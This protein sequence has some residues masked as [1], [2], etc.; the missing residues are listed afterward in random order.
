MAIRRALKRLVLIISVCLGMMLCMSDKRYLPS[1]SEMQS[2]GSD[3]LDIF[4]GMLRDLKHTAAV[5]PSSPWLVN[6]I[7][8]YVPL[9][10]TIK[11]LEVGAG[12]GTVTRKIIERMTPGSSL[13]VVEYSPELFDALSANLGKERDASNG[14][15]NFYRASIEE[16]FPPYETDG[17]Y[18]LIISTIPR[19][20]LPFTVVQKI[21]DRYD[22]MLASGGVLVSVTLAGATAMTSFSKKQSYW[23]A[24]VG[25]RLTSGYTATL[26]RSRGDLV[27]YQDRIE[28][29]SKWEQERLRPLGTTLVCLNIPPV[30]VFGFRKR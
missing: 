17:H 8:Q 9:N 11:I 6:A 22:Q 24:A 7:A 5:S 29:I 30:Y 20:Q 13:D 21:L 15:I 2:Y 12:P 23:W 3:F 10:S 16:W 14:K 19:T 18:D 4:S 27:D 25:N 1:V 28:L 26:E